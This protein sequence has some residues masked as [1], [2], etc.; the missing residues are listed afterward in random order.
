MKNGANS[1]F[2]IHLLGIVGVTV[3]VWRALRRV[4]LAGNVSGGEHLL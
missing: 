3:R 1:R 4:R 2:H